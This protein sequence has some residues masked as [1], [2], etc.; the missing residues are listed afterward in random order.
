MP[1][2]KIKEMG[3]SSKRIVLVGGP[4]GGETMIVNAR[5][6]RIEIP[7]SYNRK[8]YSSSEFWMGMFEGPFDWRGMYVIH[9]YVSTT[10]KHGEYPVFV[11]NPSLTYEK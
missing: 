5:A 7:V 1:N 2:K 8:A 3:D 11:W 10:N 9:V 6:V 4:S